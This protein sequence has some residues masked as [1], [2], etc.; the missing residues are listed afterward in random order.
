MASA[1]NRQHECYT[2]TLLYRAGRYRGGRRQHG[3]NGDLLAYIRHGHARSQGRAQTFADLRDGISRSNGINV[4][5][6]QGG[7]GYGG[8]TREAR[9]DGRLRNLALKDAH[10]GEV[11]IEPRAR[12]R[13]EV[14]HAL[15]EEALFGG[16]FVN[17]GVGGGYL[18]R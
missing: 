5:I 1:W 15:R 6:E 9:G 10:F 14:D 18:G 8:R 7:A 2:H 12:P 13:N 4:G 3:G 11:G 16:E 17:L